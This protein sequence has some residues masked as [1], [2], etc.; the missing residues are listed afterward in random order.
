MVYGACCMLHGAWCKC[1][2]VM[3]CGVQC[4]AWLQHAASDNPARPWYT[5]AKLKLIS[6][7]TVYSMAN[8]SY[9]IGRSLLLSLL[10][11][12]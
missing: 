8:N 10:I 7:Y 5:A 2:M 12:K 6:W 1:W 3:G 11:K 4:T 9:N